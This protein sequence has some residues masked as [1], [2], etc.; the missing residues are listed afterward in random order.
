[1]A[2][3]I[4]LFVVPK[5]PHKGS[6]SPGILTWED[7]NTRIHWGV[8]LLING[9]MTL[10]QASKELQV[11]EAL[12]NFFVVS[13][14]C[15]AASMFTEL[16]SNAAA[17]S[18]MLPLVL[19]MALALRVH[20]YYFALPVTAGCSFSFMLP[21]ATPPNAI[22]YELGK[23][24]IIHMA[25]WCAYCMLWMSLFW[26]LEL[27]PLPVTAL[28]P[29]VLFPL[30][31]ILGTDKTTEAYFNNY[32]FI[33]FTSLILA[34]AIEASNVH[35][36]I[37]LKLLLLLG[38][39]TRALCLMFMLVAMAMSMWIPNTT[40]TAVMTPI[41]LGVVDQMQESAIVV[42]RNGIQHPEV[43]SI[44]ANELDMSIR[45]ESLRGFPEEVVVGIKKVL[46][47]AVA[48]ATNIGGTG[49]MIGS[50]PNLILKGVFERQFPDARELT[51]TS[52]MLYNVPPMLLCVLLGWLYIQSLLLS[53][54][55]SSFFLG[56]RS[57]ALTS[58]FPEKQLFD[59]L[60]Y[61]I[62]ALRICDRALYGSIVEL[63]GFVSIEEAM[64]LLTVATRWPDA[65]DRRLDAF[66]GS[67]QTSSSTSS[68]RTSSF[69]LE[70]TLEV[71]LDVVFDL[72]LEV[73]LEVVP[74]VALKVLLESAL[75][76]AFGVVLE[77]GVQNDV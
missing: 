20:P 5:E 54:V 14:L 31:G 12:P 63:P 41:V 29:L 42:C 22:V 19:E 52:W 66:E 8:I 72:V 18:I 61:Q 34:V 64:A 68:F 1:M 46:L 73:F 59:A 49:T 76:V 33:M 6:A 13:I 40:A 39:S 23:F 17:S 74:E 27:I 21:V 71:V 45:R 4:L 75:D 43:V 26:V 30:L 57:C 51:F 28:L 25:G 70:I 24:N 44:T 47:L 55:A 36:R 2:V 15:F 35:K 9:S 37:A 16:T 32:G 65:G 56:S 60:C 11:L 50:G 67:Y 53:V 62:L 10:A 7:A 77:D 38:A 69:V 58:N 48:Y 3:A